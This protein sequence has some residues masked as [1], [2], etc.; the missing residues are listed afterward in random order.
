MNPNR[1]SKF[2]ALEELQ[3]FMVRQ[4]TLPK[5][6]LIEQKLIQLETFV[7]QLA[8]TPNGRAELQRRQL[9]YGEC[10]P[11]PGESSEQYYA[12]LRYWI[13]R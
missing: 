4:Q 10:K 9:R 6:D 3:D 7:R 5:S 8:H 13:D 12:R 1:Y 11:N 2:E